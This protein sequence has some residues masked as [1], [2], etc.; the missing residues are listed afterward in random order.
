MRQT[1]F[2]MMLLVSTT[3]GAAERRHVFAV[4]PTDDSYTIEPVTKLTTKLPDAQL[5]LYRNG[6]RVGSVTAGEPR[7]LGCVSNAADATIFGD[8]PPLGEV[9]LATSFQVASRSTRDREITEA[10]NTALTR[11]ARV[12]LREHKID[13]AKLNDLDVNARVMDAGGELLV[14]GS[15]SAPAGACAG[16]LFLIARVD[17]VTAEKVTPQVARFV[18]AADCDDEAYIQQLDHLDFDGDGF[19]EIVA[20]E[21]GKE[22]YEYLT[23]SRDAK[24]AW[25]MVRGGR[26]GC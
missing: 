16:S 2:L 22:G 4:F 10:E 17:D 20:R 3:L 1:L 19:D 5:H 14:V 26:L 23:W 25:T 7:S 12:F 13:D 21:R 11:Y 6:M 8:K 24:G 9:F 18:E 15:W